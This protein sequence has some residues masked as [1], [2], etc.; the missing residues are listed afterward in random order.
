MTIR[1]AGL[2]DAGG[3]S[4]IA[5]HGFR[6]CSIV[7]NR[8][9]V[10]TEE[11]S[12]AS[13]WRSAPDLVDAGA[14]A[15]R[16]HPRHRSSRRRSSLPD[17]REVPLTGD[18]IGAELVRTTARRGTAQLFMGQVLPV[19]GSADDGGAGALLRPSD[20][21]R[22]SIAAF[23]GLDEREISWVRTSPRRFGAGRHG[24]EAAPRVVGEAL[25]SRRAS[26]RR[27][28]RG[29]REPSS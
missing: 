10:P 5:R 26:A 16:S 9:A 21:I 28:G 13:S 1:T 15:S 19:P 18:A 2:Q 20:E 25:R 11:S 12:R 8:S 24:V 23:R 3:R 22:R 6:T 14:D 4:D 17:V 29:G 7:S 27:R